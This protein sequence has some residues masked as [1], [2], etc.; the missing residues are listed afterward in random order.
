MCGARCGL[1]RGPRS[2][3][4]G[5]PDRCK[6]TGG[7]SR[8]RE[9]EARSASGNTHVRGAKPPRACPRF[10]GEATLCSARAKRGLM[11]VGRMN[12][13]KRVHPDRL[14]QV[15]RRAPAP[16]AAGGWGSATS[17]PVLGETKIRS[18]RFMRRSGI[19]PDT[20]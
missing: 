10:C 14:H 12:E 3:S 11:L 6:A 19:C 2:K 16:R 18:T 15:V 20:G 9:G 8:V 1:R 5:V 13:R 17:L 4:A 7:A